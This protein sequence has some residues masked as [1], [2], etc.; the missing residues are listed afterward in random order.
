MSSARS[1]LNWLLQQ[2]HTINKAGDPVGTAAV[3]QKL[4]IHDAQV[5]LAFKEGVKEMKKKRT[6]NV[7]SHI[8]KKKKAPGQESA[9]TGQGDGESSE[10]E[11]QDDP[12]RGNIKETLPDENLCRAMLWWAAATCANTTHATHY[13]HSTL[14]TL[15]TT[16]SPRYTPSTLHTL[17]ATHAPRYTRYTLRR[18]FTAP[19][20]GVM[21]SGSCLPKLIKGPDPPTPTQIIPYVHST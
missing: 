7:E 20:H 3:C 12:L 10:E 21:V 9:A 4:S 18:S 6:L 11:M 19:M 17:H 13:T 1:A 14:H 2:A 15:H 8:K 16:H 5:S